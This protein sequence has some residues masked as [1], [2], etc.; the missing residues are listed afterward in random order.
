ME[1]Y[2]STRPP[3]RKVTDQNVNCTGSNKVNKDGEF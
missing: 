2:L 1:F 3:R